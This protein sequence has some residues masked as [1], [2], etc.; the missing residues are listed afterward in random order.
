MILRLTN[1]NQA[2]TQEDVRHVF[3]AFWR[4]E[5]ARTGS[6]HS[7]LG[8]TLAQVAQSPVGFVGS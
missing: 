5:P 8:L 6:T 3:E 4:K 2:L 1:D 7:G